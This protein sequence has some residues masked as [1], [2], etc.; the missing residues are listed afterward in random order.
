MANIGIAN[1]SYYTDTS[2]SRLKRQVDVSVEKISSNKANIANGD[3]TSLVSM[4]NTFKLDLA[5]TNSAVKNMTL[6]QAYTS[7]AIAAIDNASAILKQIHSL[8]VL[9]ANGS[10]SDADN[11]AIDMEAEALADAFHQALTTAQFK[12]REIFSDT[13]SSSYMAAGGQSKELQFGVGKIEYDFFYDY[14]NPAV[15]ELD[16]G[17]KYEVKR[18]L[19]DAEITSILLRDPSISASALV[20]GFQFILPEGSNNI[21]E[22]AIEVLNS[23][24]NVTTYTPGQG[25]LQIDPDATAT[26]QGDFRG[27]F[28]DIAVAKNF[29]VTDR[30]TLQD[31]NYDN[32][33]Q[34]IRIND[35]GVISFTFDDPNDA[36]DM[37]IITVDIGEVDATDD[38]TAGLLR[39]NL[40]GDATTPG[41]GN[42]LNGDFEDD[43]RT[44][45]LEPFKVWSN[46]GLEHRTGMVDTYTVTGGTGY[47]Q[48]QDMLSTDLDRGSDTYSISFVSTNGVGTGFRA[49]LSVDPITESVDIFE[50]L[51]KGQGYVGGEILTIDPADA[52]GQAFLDGSPLGNGFQ[53]EVDSVLNTNPGVNADNLHPVTTPNFEP[54]VDV[55]TAN[56]AVDGRYDWGEPYTGGSVQR[57]ATG[58]NTGDTVNYRHRTDGHYV[59]GGSNGDGTYDG[60][61]FQLNIDGVETPQT[62]WAEADLYNGDG[63]L[64]VDFNPVYTA[65]SAGN[66][67][68]VVLEQISVADYVNNPGDRTGSDRAIIKINPDTGDRLDETWTWAEVN[69]PGGLGGVD[70]IAS[71]GQTINPIVDPN[72]VVVPNDDTYVADPSRYVDS[73]NTTSIETVDVPTDGYD[74]VPDNWSFAPGEPATQYYA[75]G[76]GAYSDGQQIKIQDDAGAEETQIRHTTSD[77]YAWTIDNTDFIL[78][79]GADGL[80]YSAGDIALE[81]VA[82]VDTDGDGVSDDGVDKDAPGAGIEVYNDISNAENIQPSFYTRSVGTVRYNLAISH[83]QRTVTDTWNRQ[84][85]TGYERPDV[86]FYTRNVTLNTAENATGEQVDKYLNEGLVQFDPA[87]V[88]DEHPLGQVRAHIGWDQNEQIL[89]DHWTTYDNRVE[90]GSTFQIMD[91]GFGETGPDSRITSSTVDGSYNDNSVARTVPTPKIEDMAKPDYGD[92]LL[93]G[94]DTP[95]NDAIK[96]RDDALTVPVLQ[97]GAGTVDDPYVDVRDYA[98]TDIPPL[99]T[100]DVAVGLVEDQTEPLS[101][102]ALELFTGKIRFEEEAAYGIYHGPAVVSDQ[103]RAEQGQFLRLNY[104]AAG[105]VD[106]FHVAGYI[107]EVDPVSGA[108][109]THDNGDYKITMALSETGTREPSGRASVEIA[110]GGDYRFVF[111]V[112]TFDESGGEQAG[113]SM[114]I[115]NIVAEFPYSI[116]EDA[117]AA[118]LQSAHYSTDASTTLTGNKTITSTLR[119]S[120]DSHL[121][122]DDAIIKMEGFTFTQ[123]TDGGFM[124]A[125]TLNLATTPSEG[126]TGNANILTSKIEAV[127]ERL[128]TARVQ[129]GSQY[130]AFEEAINVTTDLKS[131]IGLA[132]GTLSDLNFS[133]ET[134]NLTRRQMQQDVA[135]TILAQ[136]NKTQSSLVSLVDG[137]YRTYLNAQFSHLK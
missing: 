109:L 57:I 36:P 88:S 28:L 7:T 129:A 15:T 35:S 97:T 27:G 8:A 100:P 39:I 38:G 123:E 69:G 50:V 121:L 77:T 92:F 51:D 11:A 103:F 40:Y 59:Y 94:T 26:V 46:N 21:G 25:N 117:V 18:K 115:D 110:N 30:L 66:N 128:N 45:G 102:N 91:S 29:E 75:W 47:T 108:P 43:L 33:Q 82:W 14:D 53:I 63:D 64:I 19:T 42:L 1:A 31:L 60:T 22:G 137:S 118:L 65:D 32:G 73:V 135:T 86:A 99:D 3:K 10:N 125:P 105:D 16:S 131:Q 107:Y 122:T 44:L 37:G 134:V 95:A 89:I 55:V 106:D 83:Y 17:I 133:M 56:P 48:K 116:S 78:R 79:N 23:K 98:D 130:A 80:D 96:N 68:D 54:D 34:K 87:R 41:S 104:T 49:N 4:D 2:I 124:L 6:G 84:E 111:I 136:A 85:I 52:R 113:A 13:P 101:G 114:R 112:G 67:P 71:N 126:S 81:Q 20:P 120:D 90:F 24:G 9:G 12:G 93:L 127:Q 5:A 132:S 74:P 62:L 58:D 119:N 76:G 72:V 70:N 61:A